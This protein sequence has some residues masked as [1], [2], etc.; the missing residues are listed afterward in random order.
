MYVYILY[1]EREIE[2]ERA[3]Q[4]CRDV[5]GERRREREGEISV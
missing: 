1:R 2:R 4:M 5:Y 3:H